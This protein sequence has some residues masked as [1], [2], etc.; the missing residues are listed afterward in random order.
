MEI[1]HYL[2]H[3]L[4]KELAKRKIKPETLLKDIPQDIT[5]VLKAAK[6]QAKKK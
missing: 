6:A 1:V 3:A 5:R 4:D 2:K